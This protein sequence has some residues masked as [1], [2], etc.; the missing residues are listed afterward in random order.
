[1][2]GS[3][4]YNAEFF[5]EMKNKFIPTHETGL[6]ISNDFMSKMKIY[7]RGVINI[8]VDFYCSFC[9]PHVEKL[10]RDDQKRLL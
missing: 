5:N 9:Q 10:H 3:K 7:V 2:E 4:I 6:H 1:M 8:T